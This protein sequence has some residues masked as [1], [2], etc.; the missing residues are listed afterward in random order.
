ARRLAHQFLL[1]KDDDGNVQLR[2]DSDGE[3][4]YPVSRGLRDVLESAL[5]GSPDLDEVLVRGGHE[6]GERACYRL[7]EKIISQFAHDMAETI[8]LFLCGNRLAICGACKLADH[9]QTGLLDRDLFKACLRAVSQETA[10]YGG[11]Q[12]SR[13]EA[14]Q[15]V[16]LGHGQPNM[17]L[18]ETWLTVATNWAAQDSAPTQSGA[19]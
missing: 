16:R 19:K 9:Q 7:H 12:T 14:Q 6:P 1:V 11:W 5:P 13:T 4:P 3:G 8:L 18:S 10:S 15:H 17:P 2:R